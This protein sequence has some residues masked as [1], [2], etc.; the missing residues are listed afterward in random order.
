[1]N[2]A[3]TRTRAGWSRTGGP[4]RGAAPTASPRLLRSLTLPGFRLTT[5][6]AALLGLGLAGCDPGT[7]PEDDLLSGAWQLDATPFESLPVRVRMTL[8]EDADGR[9]GGA[10]EWE[11]FRCR[12]TGFAVVLSGVHRGAQVSFQLNFGGSLVWPFEGTLSNDG[13]HVV[14]ALGTYPA[15]L[16]RA[17]GVAPAAAAACVTPAEG[18]VRARPTHPW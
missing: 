7:S 1:M 16:M 17:E 15:S 3:A 11:Q 4:H 13:A 5:L 14:G 6:T 10:G 2:T 12:A 8:V 18:D 9:L